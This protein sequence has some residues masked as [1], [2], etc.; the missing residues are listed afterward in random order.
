MSADGMIWS[1]EAALQRA[2]LAAL[3]ADADVQAVLGDPARIFDDESPA[4]VFPYARLERHEVA[5]RSATGAAG[6]AHTLSFG[7][8]CRDGGRAAAKDAVGALRAAAEAADLAL[9][10]QRVVLIQPVYS[11][12]VRT[13]DLREFRGL[14]RIRIITEEAV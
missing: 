14:L 8:R 9:A 10:G 5:E 7:I 6:Q 1:A 4:P 2:F 11:D 13:P 3:R 12:V